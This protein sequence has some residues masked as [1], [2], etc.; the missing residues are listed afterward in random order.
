MKKDKVFI[1]DTTLR[2]GEQSPGASLNHRDKLEIAGQ[3]AKLNVDVIEA[4]F[5]IAS[6]DDFKAVQDIA[7]TVKGPSICGL[8][9]CVR[10]DIERCAEA[11]APAGKPRIHVFLAT[12]EIHRKF[13]LMKARSEI[14][15][16]AVAH[17]KYAR[18]FCDDVE[19]S[20]EDASRTE[21]DFL[22]EVVEAVIDAG[23][24]TVNIPDTV[25]YSVPS[26]FGALI[27]YLFEHV[28]NV[29][30]AVLS[31]H[32]HNDL[33]LAVANS[34]A[35]VQNGARCIECTINGLGERAGNAALE[36]IVMALQTRS[37]L[38]SAVRTD[39][40]TKNLHKTSRMVSRLTGMSVQRNKA[41]VGAN[42]FAH[43]SGVHQDGMLKERRT[44]EIMRPEE[45]G[46]GSTELVLGKHS[47][48]HGL[49]H[50]LSV[51][52]V[53]VPA[54]KFEAVYNRFLIL[55]DKK[56]Q[57]YDDDLMMLARDEFDA[58]SSVYVLDAMQVTTGTAAVP[59]ATVQL[60]KGKQVLRDAACGDGPVDAVIKTINRL[61][62]CKGRIVDFSL[63]AI[64]VGQ[65][66]M[67][68]ACVTVSFGAEQL[69]DKAAST[70]IIE[71]SA[72]AYLSCVNRYLCAKAVKK[73]GHGR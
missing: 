47:G 72:K 36:E 63:Q 41:I 1:F 44:Y 25:G 71:A 6:P 15:K 53:D 58:P 37:D 51:L 28:P 64:T 32:C 50:R 39:I 42:A 35:A 31:V 23:A 11:V 2:D 61:T 24:G 17:V 10:A 65:D 45:V 7:R 3:L 33:G 21:P 46:I 8:A 69:S 68:E 57:V 60:K 26:E 73:T 34:L 49:K 30:N 27:A 62:G 18:T 20:P 22:D 16:Q 40:V 5:P 56:K 48:R 43:E 59:T 13:K 70:D 66:A 4:G 14:L 19:F 9:R 67:G 38:F 54:V 52:G 12:S 29:K 55:A